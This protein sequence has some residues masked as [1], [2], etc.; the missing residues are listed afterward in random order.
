[1][2][3]YIIQDEQT[4]GIKKALP[5]FG[6]LHIDSE[7]IKGGIRVVGYRK[8]SWGE[9]VDVEFIGKIYARVKWGKMEWFDSSIMTNKDVKV[10]K[11]RV[12]RLI[13]RCLLNDVKHRLNYFGVNINEISQITKLKWL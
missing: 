6:T 1:M 5:K 7:K 12:N 13:R 4:K 8:Y 9:Q 10:S 2:A 11:V 3:R